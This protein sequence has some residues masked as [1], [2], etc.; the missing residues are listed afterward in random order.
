[1]T[2][3][4]RLKTFALL[5]LIAGPIGAQTQKSPPPTDWQIEAQVQQA[6]ANEHA[7]KGSTIISGVNKGVVTLTGNV[8]S[9][10]EKALVSQDL[11]NIEGVKTV[12]NNLTIVDG[13]PHAPAVSTAPT[14][15]AK[16]L[17]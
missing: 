11:A 2:H 6:L 14:L 9:E 3:L 15:T 4:P 12:L 17:T 13:S 16:R 1:M 10:A 7:F 5:T 8:R